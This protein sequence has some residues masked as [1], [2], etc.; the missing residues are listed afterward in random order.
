MNE[1]QRI[2]R[3]ASRAPAQAPPRVDVADRVMATL[4][5]AEEAPALDARPLAWVAALSA[6]GAAAV[7]LLA[8][9]MQASWADVLLAAFTDV[10]EWML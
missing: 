2:R 1:E 4:R 7:T 10:P 9:S 6:A 3:L 5:R 8:F